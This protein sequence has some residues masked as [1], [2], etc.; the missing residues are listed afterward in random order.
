MIVSLLL[1]IRSLSSIFPESRRPRIIGGS[2]AIL[3]EF[4]YMVSIRL[5]SQETIA[6]GEG[7][8]CSGVLVSSKDVLTSAICVQ[9][10]SGQRLP[11]EIKLVLGITSRTN[12]TGMIEASAN[13]IWTTASLAIMRLTTDVTELKPVVLN[14]FKQQ[15]GKQ[16]LL[17]GWGANSSIRY[18]V[19]DMQEV[20]VR[21]TTDNCPDGMICAGGE[22]IGSG[23]CFGDIGSPLLCDGSLVGIMGSEPKQCGGTVVAFHSILRHYNWIKSQIARAEA[24]TW[25]EF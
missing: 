2:N 23:A 7:F 21:I 14:E 6:F 4:P 20:Y 9:N 25:V 22:R 3:S 13:I 12:S 10:G 1:P 24:V 11:E 16:C 17:V 19:N 18:M 8:Y 5:A 15:A